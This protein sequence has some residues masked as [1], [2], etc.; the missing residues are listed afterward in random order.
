[1]EIIQPDKYN[2]LR[3]KHPCLKN[4]QL[5]R[6]ET[7]GISK[8]SHSHAVEKAE[9]AGLQLF[10]M[11]CCKDEKEFTHACQGSPIKL[12]HSRDDAGHHVILQWDI[13]MFSLNNTVT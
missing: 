3:E 8:K 10:I 4:V 1:M 7:E 6:I 2:A 11:E 5:I 9:G 13:Q 12:N